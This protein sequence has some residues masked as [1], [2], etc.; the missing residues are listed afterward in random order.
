MVRGE[1]PRVKV[2]QTLQLLYW[3]QDENLRTV[4]R[5]SAGA[6]GTAGVLLVQHNDALAG[7]FLPCHHHLVA[8]PTAVMRELAMRGFICLF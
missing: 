6:V 2:L 7:P 5:P 3:Y 1:I 8:Q 4:V